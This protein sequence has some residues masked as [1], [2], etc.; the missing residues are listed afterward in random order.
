V[1]LMLSPLQP[2]QKTRFRSKNRNQPWFPAG[3]GGGICRH[4]EGHWLDSI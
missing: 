1:Y 3:F 2:N 4:G